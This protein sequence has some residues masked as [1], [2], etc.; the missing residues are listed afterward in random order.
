MATA[1]IDGLDPDDY[2]PRRLADAIDD[3][4]SGS[5]KALARAETLLSRSFVRYVRDLHRPADVGMIFVDQSLAPKAPSSTAILDAAAG[6][7]SARKPLEDALPLHPIYRQLRKSAA[8]WM[9]RWG[10]LPNVRV[11]AG[12]TIAAGATGDRVERLRYRLGLDPVGSF[13]RS[14]AA[15]V[16]EFQTA[17]GL[18]A[19]GSADPKTIA[20]L[21]EPIEQQQARIRLNLERARV[22]PSGNDQRY[23]LVDAAAAR[24]WLY[25]G[26]RARDSMRA[27]V[28]R[29]TEPTPMIAAKIDSAVLNPYWNVPPDLVAKRIAPNVLKEGIGHLKAARYEVLSD[30]T[31]DAKLV[32]PKTVDWAAVAAG[33]KELPMRQLPGPANS[34]GAMK[35]MFPNDFGVYLHDTPEKT[36]FGQADRR[37]SAG[38]VR[39]EDAQRLAKWLFGSVPRAKSN[40]PEQEVALPEPVPVYI[41]YL[42][43]APAERGIVFRDDFYG[44]DKKALAA[45]AS[46]TRSRQLK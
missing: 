21:N 26:G 9:E 12:T 15:A 34:M 32:D 28:G 33:R 8:D 46:R 4:Q 31:D 7:L 36:L 16:R 30:W 13:D 20:L 29:V 39:V 2:Q 43:A 22:L 14:V 10:S 24:L 19:T 45:Y 17:H 5:P 1:D 35:F 40:K 6:A 41:T 3:A 44:R 25:E 11:P 27:I 18:A 38:C 37:Q 23:V 42:T